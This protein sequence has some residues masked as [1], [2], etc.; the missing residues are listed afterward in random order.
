[1]VRNF[2]GEGTHG[3]TCTA[4]TV[5]ADDGATAT[6]VNQNATNTIQ[7]S[8]VVAH[9]FSTSIRS[10]SSAA[11]SGTVVR[12]PFTSSTVTG[13]TRLYHRAASLPPVNWVVETLRQAS[14]VSNRILVNTDGSVSIASSA[15]TVL[16]TTAAGAWAINR[17]NRID[18]WFDGNGAAAT[19][20]L[21]LAVYDAESGT[22]TGTASRTNTT[23]TTPIVAIDIGQPVSNGAWEHWYDTVGLEVGVTA[24]IG[25]YVIPSE[26]R[27]GTLSGSGTLSAT[28][29]STVHNREVA[30]SGSGTLSAEV[31][32]E[33][34]TRS[35]ALSGSGSLAGVATSNPARSVALSGAGT[36]SVAVEVL[37]LVVAFTGSG[38][39]GV[40]NVVGVETPPVT[41]SYWEKRRKDFGPEANRRD[42][43]PFWL[44]SYR[45]GKTLIRYA[46]GTFA[47]VQVVTEELEAMEGIRILWGGKDNRVTDDEAAELIAAGY[48]DYLSTADITT[49]ED[50]FGA[51]L[52]SEGDY[53]A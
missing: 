26:S 32:G 13:A 49:P 10:S 45:Q 34:H 35:V 21:F 2:L 43:M 41:F 12:L 8:N 51:G 31:T 4:G 42:R 33:V 18:V 7:F 22:A 11:Q 47:P 36:L 53:G 38:T 40:M 46:D 28:V 3:A 20:D 30:L 29:D 50:A 48:G 16:A 27:N 6:S 37:P 52:Y 15:G 39:L 44:E 25:P 9:T 14:A 19:H 24:F 23:V 17:W 5:V 1:M